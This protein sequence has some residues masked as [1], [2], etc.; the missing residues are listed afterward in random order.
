MARRF[1]L[2]GSTHVQVDG[3]T[4]VQPVNGTLFRGRA[5]LV[6]LV[7]GVPLSALLLWFAVRNADLE[8]VR[9][10]LAESDLGPVAL[11]GVALAGVY[12]M[13]AVRWRAVARTPS[14]SPARFVEMVVSGLAVNNVLPGRVGDLLRARWLQLAARI[15]A[16]RALAS[17][18]VDKSFDVLALV[19]FLAVSLPFVASE[20]WL[21]RIAAGGLALLCGVA[22]VLVGARLYARRRTRERRGRRSL[23][24]RLAR[25]TVEGLAEP[26]GPLRAVRLSAM[27]LA[28]WAMWAVAAWL[29][30][31][32]VGVELSAI[33][34][35]FVTAVINLG[36][37]IPSSPGFIGTYQWLGVSALSLFG[38]PTEQS[39]AFSI[40]M[41]AVWY[42]P[43]LLVGGTLLARRA[44]RATRARSGRPAAAAEVPDA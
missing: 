44:V 33:E 28:V 8:E 35:V 10:V 17:V 31:R 3:S 21:H 9:S 14:V 34:V 30:A 19:V 4:H 40:L 16:G 43:T 1:P 37:A 32:A 13:Q 12:T 39:L 29:V 41:Q 23:L 22:L 18:F 38:V 5:T 42:V 26:I 25:D 7:V 11:A 36:V 20:A 27:S 2:D 6:G 15:A 24:R